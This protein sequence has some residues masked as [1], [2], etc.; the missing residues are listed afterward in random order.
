MKLVVEKQYNYKSIYKY[1]WNCCGNK[2]GILSKIK[3]FSSLIKLSRMC[4]N[5]CLSASG[6]CLLML[7]CLL[8]ANQSL[9]WMWS[10]SFPRHESVY[11]F[12]TI[13]LS[14]LYL[15]LLSFVPGFK[16]KQN[17]RSNG[18]KS[19]QQSTAI[20]CLAILY[21][22]RDT[23]YQYLKKKKFNYSKKNTTIERAH[24][25]HHTPEITLSKKTWNINTGNTGNKSSP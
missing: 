6:A 20:F 1:S 17:S 8:W 21:P 7:G 9:M 3:H 23:E 4:Y 13:L 12:H 16:K 2:V 5:L 18:K 25:L 14:L 10:S 19:I 15:L 24:P 22:Y 11:C